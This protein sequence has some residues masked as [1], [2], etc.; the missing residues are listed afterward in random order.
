MHVTVKFKG[1][2]EDILENA[3]EEGIAK[4]KTEALRLGV[5]E[6]ANKYN[7]L[8]SDKGM[9]VLKM[10][11]LDKKGSFA[12]LKEVKKKYPGVFE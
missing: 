2:I 7:L 11:K 6:L 1:V 8:E 12:K 3:V 9:A 4:T 10:K 5:L